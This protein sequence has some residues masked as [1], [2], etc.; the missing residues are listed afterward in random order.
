MTIKSLKALKG[1]DVEKVA[2]AIEADA[3]EA[4]SGLRESLAEAQ[5][6]KF[7]AVHTPEQLAARKRGRPVGSVKADPKVAT[8]IRL[9]AEVL[10][11][12]KAAGPGWQTRA[13]DALRAAFVAKKA[14][15]RVPRTTA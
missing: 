10:E 8:T 5:A 12:L 1:L 7:A 13:N 14:A 4:L 15:P 2:K 11:A 6:G 9:D 3:G